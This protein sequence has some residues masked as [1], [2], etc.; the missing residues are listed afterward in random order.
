MQHLTSVIRHPSS[1][2]RHPSSVLVGVVIGVAVTC[3]HSR[4]RTQTEPGWERSY[5]TPATVKPVLA[6]Q[7]EGDHVKRSAN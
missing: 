6:C 4:F 3:I 7:L 1:V 2:I 5:D